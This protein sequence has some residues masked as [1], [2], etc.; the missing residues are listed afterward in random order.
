MNTDNENNRFFNNVVIVGHAGSDTEIKY[1]DSGSAKA[2]V[3]LAV[4]RMGKNK[5]KIIRL[6]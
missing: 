6:R 5:E 1:F 3:S 4:N 2:S